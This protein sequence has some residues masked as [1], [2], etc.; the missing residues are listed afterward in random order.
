MQFTLVEKFFQ[1]AMR[2]KKNYQESPK[3]AQKRGANFSEL[4]NA[5]LVKSIQLKI[6]T[7]AA[8]PLNQNS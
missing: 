4:E 1:A 8:T 7:N 2:R 3:E 5:Q 6:L